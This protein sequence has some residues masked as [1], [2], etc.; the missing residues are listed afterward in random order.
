MLD[1]AG[2]DELVTGPATELLPGDLDLHASFQENQELGRRMAMGGINVAGRVVDRER[3][4]ALLFYFMGDG[5]SI[6][7]F[8]K[9]RLVHGS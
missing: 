1:I 9:V 6:D 7:R 4:K 2:N 8:V 5:I 3:V